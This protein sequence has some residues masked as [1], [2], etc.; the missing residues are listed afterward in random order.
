MRLKSELWVQAFLRQN[1]IEGRFGAV[2]KRGAAEAGAIFVIVNHLDGSHHLFGPP[3]G[4][5]IDE[6]GNRLWMVEL[7]PPATAVDVDALLAKR[8]RFD[9]DIWI[10]EV[11]DRSGTAG[12]VAVPPA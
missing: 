8:R 3:P 9:T 4:S 11:E 12:L 5:S 10:V 7:S 2:V 6:M 1:E